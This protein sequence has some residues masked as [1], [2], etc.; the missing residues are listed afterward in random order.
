MASIPFVRLSSEDLTP[1]HDDLYIDTGIVD[2]LEKLA[3]GDPLILKGPKGTGKTLAIEEFCALVGAPRVRQNCTSET[4]KRE[5]L[6][7]MLYQGDTL[8]FSM[9]T[10]TTAIDVANEQG[11]C[12]LI[13]EEINKLPPTNHSMLFSVADFRRAVEVPY[14]GKIF[15]V[16]P[17]CQFWIVGTMNPGYSGTY[18]LNEALQSRFNFAEVGYMSEAQE[19]IL[20]ETL[21]QKISGSPPAVKERRLIKRLLTFAAET[22][23]NKFDYALS[24]RDLSY[25]IRLYHQIGLERALKMLEGKF[26]PE[27]MEA[28]RKRVQSIFKVNL[29]TVELW[30]L[31]P[32]KK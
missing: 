9:G 31:N 14:L 26:E 7:T 8:V 13:I 29:A 25:F 17:G 11:A 15:K 1:D 21:L 6:G 24:P 16:N 27:H 12:V 3:W 22:R 20:L 19:S 10:L 30:C 18:T 23:T 2:T 28:I 32:T 5:F 4:D